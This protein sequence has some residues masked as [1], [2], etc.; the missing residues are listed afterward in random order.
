MARSP[1]RDAFNETFGKGA[2]SATPKRSPAIAPWMRSRQPTERSTPDQSAA[3]PAATSQGWGISLP[4]TRTPHR[5][6]RVT[7]TYNPVAQQVAPR[8][9][10][11]QGAGIVLP[12][13]TAKATENSKPFQPSVQYEEQTSRHYM[14][15]DQPTKLLPTTIRA[16]Q[17]FRT[18]V[19]K[20]MEQEAYDALTPAQRVVVD[21]NTALAEARSSDLSGRY[22]DVSKW[23]EGYAERAQNVF[24][25]GTTQ[26]A[27]KTMALLESLQADMRGRSV[28]DV[29]NRGY[30]IGIDELNRSQKA[31]DP[32]QIR[33]GD[34]TKNIV[35]I[36]KPGAAGKP[37]LSRSTYVSDISKATAE[38]LLATIQK[39]QTLLGG[40]ASPLNLDEKATSDFEYLYDAV[41]NPVLAEDGSIQLSDKGYADIVET[42]ENSDYNLESFLTYADRRLR[43][44]MADPSQWLTDDA[45]KAFSDNLPE[46][47]RKLFGSADR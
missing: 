26:Y 15:K 19:S 34:N 30:D 43:S 6:F 4:A 24:G 32:Q 3:R 35:D 47:R 45:W 18:S 14:A 46:I 23:E 27:P 41:V 7:D 1:I 11:A 40:K 12:V 29:L 44:D 2:T 22:T 20:Q 42:I 9:A 28:G 16:Q 31:T 21:F 33:I 8:A 37:D 38:R 17:G 39:G 10:T 25:E 13:T 5:S 36:P